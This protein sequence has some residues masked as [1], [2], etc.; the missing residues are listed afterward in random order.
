LPLTLRVAPGSPR[1]GRISRKNEGLVLPEVA[2]RPARRRA[3]ETVRPARDEAVGSGHRLARGEILA[4]APELRR[5]P[6]PHEDEGAPGGSEDQRRGVGPG[7]M[8]PR[9]EREARDPQRHR[10]ERAEP[11]VEPPPEGEGAPEARPERG[12]PAPCERDRKS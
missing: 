1:A 8:L 11:D 4:R 3:G 10:A 5:G 2:R 9:E 12:A 7:D 6:Q